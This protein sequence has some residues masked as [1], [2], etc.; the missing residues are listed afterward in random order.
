MAN[1][2]LYVICGLIAIWIG[3]EVIQTGVLVFKKWDQIIDYNSYHW[4]IKWIIGGIFILTGSSIVINFLRKRT[5]DYY[6]REKK[7]QNILICPK[8]EEPYYRYEHQDMLCPVCGGDM[9]V[10][11]DYYKRHPELGHGGPNIEEALATGELS[12]ALEH[13]TGGDDRLLNLMLDLIV[14]PFVIFSSGDFK[15]GSTETWLTLFIVFLNSYVCEA[16][17]GLSLGKAITGTRIVD[18]NWN[19]PTIWRATLRFL[20][21][22]IPFE[23]LSGFVSDIPPRPWRDRWSKT[24]VVDRDLL[25]RVRAARKKTGQS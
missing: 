2:I 11:G 18:R 15:Y 12:N 24:C 7:N 13:P 19:K 4:S 23:F 3:I 21:R 5:R 14:I 16:L 25:L 9:E 6:K 10:M 20:I 22:L 8:C 1:I 17:F